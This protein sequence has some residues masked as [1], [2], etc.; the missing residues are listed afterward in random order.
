M[1]LILS[2]TAVALLPSIAFTK[3]PPATDEAKAKAAETSAKTAWDD[4]V[5]AYQTCRAAD[6]VAEGYR[7][8][9]KAA[10]Q[11]APKPMATALRAPTGPY[12]SQ[13]LAKPKPLE[14]FGSHSPTETAT[15]PPSSTATAGT[16]GIVEEVAS[17][18][19]RI[20][21]PVEGLG[22]G[23]FTSTRK[24]HHEATN[25][26]LLLGLHPRVQAV[27]AADSVTF[28]QDDNYR[29][30]QFTADRPVTNFERNGFND[31]VR[32]AVVHEGRWEICMMRISMAVAACRPGRLSHTRRL[33][34]ASLGATDR[35]R[36]CQQASRRPRPQ[37]GSAGYA[38]RRPGI[39]PGVL[40]AHPTMPN[41]RMTG[42]NN[43]LLR[44]TSKPLLDFLQRGRIPGRM[45]HLRPRRLCLVA[46]PRQYDLV[47]TPD[48]ERLSLQR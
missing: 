15:S 12:V 14:A 25:Q 13:V 47:G 5:G 38:V 46:R 29:G 17:R 32:S 45:P 40:S 10:G 16:I 2:L 9:I 39:C 44:C 33:L 19:S 21:W 41:L 36:L 18:S 31:R 26:T 48:L 42:F 43:P 4:K 35:W 34:A 1:R 20:V 37:L 22:L 3:L 7:K 6:R 24:R 27:A 28:Y 23:S 30:R 11:V 8:N